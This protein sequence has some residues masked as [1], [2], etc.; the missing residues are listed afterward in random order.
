[1][2]LPLRQPAF[3]ARPQNSVASPHNREDVMAYR[4][5][6]GASVLVAAL[7]MTVTASQAFDETKYPD[8]KG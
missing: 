6:I 8:L 4:G 1:M 7:L 2:G 3:G 5:A